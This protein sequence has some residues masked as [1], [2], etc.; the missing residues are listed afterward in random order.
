VA[1]VRSVFSKFKVLNE[2]R[3]PD[4][5][6]YSAMFEVEGQQLIA[7]MAVPHKSSRPLSRCM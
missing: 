4:G 3:T 5:E 7:F 1:G 6:I 2:S